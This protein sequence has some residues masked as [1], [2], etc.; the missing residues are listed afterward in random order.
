MIQVCPGEELT[1]VGNCLADCGL[2]RVGL[3]TTFLAA[4]GRSVFRGACMH[5]LVS[6]H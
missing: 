5:W 2:R 3:T 1:V 6:L 4:V